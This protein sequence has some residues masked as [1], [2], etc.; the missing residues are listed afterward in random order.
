MKTIVNFFDKFEDHI[1]INLA[2][3]PLIYSLL[4]GT[5]TVLFWRGV[6]H[7]ADYLENNT[8]WGSLV[9]SN[10][11]SMILGVLVLLV[12]GLFVSVFIGDSIIMSG[13]R[14]DKRLIK[15]DEQ[16]I[17]GE[18]E[19]ERRMLRK[20]QSDIESLDHHKKH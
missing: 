4:G 14:S 6:W 9:F 11:G 5:G 15:K 10:I 8:Q 3:H 19:R 2:R 17:E 13:L 12:S 16:E 1:R 18:L 7:S 20:I